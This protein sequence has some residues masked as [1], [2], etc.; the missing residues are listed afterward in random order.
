MKIMIVLAYLYGGGAERVATVL[1]NSFV[2]LGHEVVFATNKRRSDE[3]LVYPVDERVKLCKC[4]ERCLE[5]RRNRVLRSLIDKCSAIRKAYYFLSYRLDPYITLRRVIAREKPAVV[6][7][8]MHTASFQALIASLGIDT[9][10]ISSEHNSFER[11]VDMPMSRKSYFFKFFVNR[12]FRAVTVLTAADKRIAQRKLRNVYV[13]PNPLSLRALDA[14]GAELRP[15]RI[16]AAGRLDVWYYKGFDLLI[17]AW[18]RIAHKCK[19]WSLEIAGQGSDDSVAC[20][21]S[22][23]KQNHVEGSVVLSGFHKDMSAVFRRAE[24]FV[25]SSRCEA[26]GMV[27]IE[28]MSQGCACVAC[29]YNGRQR[30]IVR[31]DS[32]GIVIEPGS[33]EALSGAMLHLIG[34]DAYRAEVRERGLLRSS[35]YE[36]SGIARRWLDLFEELSASVQSTK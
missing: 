20:L 14:V 10:V 3:P 5:P 2:Q 25:L 9:V 11:P 31:S 1:A 28:A 8:F 16:V 21:R 30:E 27:L 17:A 19:G 24:I 29:D 12:C 36:A 15:R 23:I 34:N 35:A 7:G 22:L 6:V 32:E 4:Y 26:F 33:V 13:M 18:G